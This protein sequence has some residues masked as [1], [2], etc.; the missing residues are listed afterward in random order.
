MLFNNSG[1]NQLRCTTAAII[2]KNLDSVMNHQREITI[3]SSDRISRI[4]IR[5]GDMVQAM[6]TANL[7]RTEKVRWSHRW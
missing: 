4:N 5:P 3:L 6:M 2:I 1:K 7:G